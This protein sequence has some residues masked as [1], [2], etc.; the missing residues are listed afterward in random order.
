MDY[1]STALTAEL[2][3]RILEKLNGVLFGSQLLPVP[4]A[5]LFRFLPRGAFLWPTATLGPLA[6]SRVIV[7]FARA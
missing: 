6:Q 3:A 4:A 5:L 2:R 1:E 7:L